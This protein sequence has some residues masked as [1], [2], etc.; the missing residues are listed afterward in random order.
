M[1]D[2]EGEECPWRRYAREVAD[3]PLEDDY[4]E[5]SDADSICNDGGV[6]G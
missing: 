3:F 4:G 1:D 2:G 6:W 5:E